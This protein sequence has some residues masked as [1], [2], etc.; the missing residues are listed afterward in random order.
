M[1]HHP[2][3]GNLSLK[4]A[5]TALPESS[6]PPI[7]DTVQ[8]PLVYNYRTKLTPHFERPP[9]AVRNDIIPPGEHPSWLQIGFNV[10]NNKSTLDIEV[11]LSE[12]E[13]PSLI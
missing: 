10:A 6:I 9:K 5:R 7:E 2:T 3:E 4:V 11:C 13:V 8:S 12:V 1:S